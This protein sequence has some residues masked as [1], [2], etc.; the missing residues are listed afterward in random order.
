[1]AIPEDPHAKAVFDGRSDHLDDWYRVA[2]AL[3]FREVLEL[4][5][6]DFRKVVFRHR[7][8]KQHLMSEPLEKFRGNR[9]RQ[10]LPVN[11]TW[12]GV[13]WAG[14]TPGFAGAPKG[15]RCA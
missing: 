12:P 6:H 2:Q 5:G 8:Q 7:L 13:F 4:R 11:P 14:S 10:A 3:P 1:M 15:L 9:V